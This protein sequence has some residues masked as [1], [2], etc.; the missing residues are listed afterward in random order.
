VAAI[1]YDFKAIGGTLL[2][3]RID[4]W[5]KAAKPEPEPKAAEPM[6]DDAWSDP[7]AGTESCR[8][9]RLGEAVALPQ[10]VR[11]RPASSWLTMASGLAGLLAIACFLAAFWS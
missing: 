2:K 11:C 6:V 5:W 3:Q 9:E 8:H 1:V 4:D 10:R 7:L